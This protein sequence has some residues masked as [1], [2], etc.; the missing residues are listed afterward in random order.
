MTTSRGA[1]SARTIHCLLA[2]LCLIACSVSSSPAETQGKR[3]TFTA[4]DQFSESVQALSARVAPSVVQISVTRYGPREESK[5][6]HTGVVLSRQQAVGSGVIIDP[7]GYIV[8]NSHVVAGAQSI[9][10]HLRPK[11]G[12]AEAGKLDLS[13]AGTLAEAYAAPLKATLIGEFKEGDLALLK[14]SATGLPA[15]PFAD[16]NKLRQGQ[17]VFAFGSPEGLN[18][19]VS[20][21]V[22]SSI[23]RQLD[24]DTPFI[25][26][27]TDAPINPGE[28]GGPLVNTAGEIVGLDTMI[29][30]QGGGSEG[31]GFAIPSPLIQ[32][33]CDQLRKQGHFHRIEMGIGIQTIT[34]NLAGALNL[35]RDS[36]VIISDVSPGGTADDAGL[37]L[38]DIVLSVDGKSLENLPMFMMAL[39]VHPSGKDVQLQVLRGAQTMPFS[40]A[41]AIQGHDSDRVTDLVN[42]ERDQIPKLGIVGLGIDKQIKAMLPDLRASYGVVVAAISERSTGTIT[43]LQAGDLIH[44]INGV[45]VT[46]VDG[47]R[48]AVNSLQR[49]APVALFIERE[50]KLQY[51]SFEIE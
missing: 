1:P 9:R 35:P 11:S 34:P 30:T 50:G 6:T 43:G 12:S 37:K 7:D 39:L 46:T 2:C 44:E 28:S 20:M 21:G 23:A 36:G 26:I 27:Q 25:Y 45:M 41:A 38:N 17:V 31:V 16:Y 33:V 29:L 40:V 18:N 5:G 51:L 19:S 24:P 4:L 42:P 32:V 3:N 10:V 47:L 13:V 8:T 48:T 22:V 14:I 15:L 49:G